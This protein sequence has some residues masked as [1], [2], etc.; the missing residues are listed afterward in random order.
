MITL[1]IVLALLSVGATLAGVVPAT[2]A[3]VAEAAAWLTFA[4]LCL[5]VAR[6]EGLACAAVSVWR[7]LAVAGFFF[8]TS[9]LLRLG[10]DG[11]KAP[12]VAAAIAATAVTTVGI[13]VAG[14]VMIRYPLEVRGPPR[15]RMRLDLAT[16]MAAFV[17]LAWY[18]CLPGGDPPGNPAQLVANVLA[19][20]LALLAVFGAIKLLLGGAAPFTLAAGVIL[21]AGVLIGSWS[22]FNML[23]V[24]P[25]EEPLIEAGQIACAF[26]LSIAARMQY[27][28][29]HHDPTGV[30]RR[31]APT[32]SRLPYLAVI[33]TQ[34]LLVTELAV[35]G[36]TLRGWGVVV[37]TVVV[38]MLVMLRQNLAFLDNAALLKRLKTSMRDLRR[39][40]ERFRSLVQHASDLTL[41][42]GA[43]GTVRFASPALWE[44]LGVDPQAAAGRPIGEV[45]RPEDVP[46]AQRLLDE[47]IASPGAD[48][49]RPLRVHHADGSSRWLEAMATNRLDD[50]SVGGVIINV[51]DVTEARVLEEQLRHQATHDPLT[52]LPNR[53]L[54]NEQALRLRQEPRQPGRH[55]AVLMLDLDDFKEVNDV[56]GHQAGDRLLTVVADRLRESVRPTDVVARLGGDEFVVLLTG[57]TRDGA[58]ATARRILAALRRPVLID[59]HEV[60]A[61]A[62]VGVAIGPGEEFDALMRAADEAMY[63]AKRD[64]TGD[65]VRVVDRTAQGGTFPA[66]RA[67]A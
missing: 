18:Q 66:A 43:D 50:P 60:D 33:G 52:G 63:Q 1:L 4:V 47:V 29:M 64:P 46:A 32:Y 27:L 25:G 24:E 67:P 38:S 11:E 15:V 54:L 20:G 7:G 44:L 17:L 51:R 59:G 57:T 2:V 26:L 28:K 36:L 22:L 5:R 34:A 53:V 56:L 65:R 3:D 31:A 6:R 55:E 12:P 23:T 13:A 39:H 35:E 14:W 45:L 42:V 30:T 9:S 62:S 8:T 16:V 40:E 58:V 10:T 49:R 48:V 41:L 21:G 37:G 61:G 19:C